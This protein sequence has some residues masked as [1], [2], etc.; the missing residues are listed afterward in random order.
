MDQQS[1]TFTTLRIFCDNCGGQN[2]N[3]H[4][5]LTVLKLVHAKRLDRVELVFMTAGH[6]YL[7]CDRMFGHIE[8]KVRSTGNI[9]STA[10][11]K[12]I[13]KDSIKQTFPVVSMEREDF[14]DVK[15]LSKYITKRPAG[16]AKACQ[17]V[18]DTKYPNSYIIKKHYHFSDTEEF[19]VVGLLKTNEEVLDL[20]KVI[21][22][23][24]YKTQCLLT[25]L[26]C[27][28]LRSLM[29]FLETEPRAWLN[30][31]L[32]NQEVISSLPMEA[33]IELDDTGSD[34]EDDLQ[35]YVAPVLLHEAAI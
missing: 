33:R 3:I 14:L 6:S 17:L 11:Y 16:F 31:L 34:E 1:Q 26:K 25:W 10:I 30:E 5:V 2:K 32:Q 4:L 35:D 22:K 24:K 29:P 18:V 15:V 28:D 12:N 9:T 19:T 8:N 7:P 21:L 20:S 13:I 27:K 23:P